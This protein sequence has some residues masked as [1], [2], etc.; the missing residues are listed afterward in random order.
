MVPMQSATTES[1]PACL[2]TQ[3]IPMSV[4]D[5]NAYSAQIVLTIELALGTGAEMLALELAVRTLCAT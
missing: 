3:A 2:N 1:A 4:A 5:L